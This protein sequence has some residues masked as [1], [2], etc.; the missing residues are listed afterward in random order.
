MQIEHLQVQRLN[1]QQLQGIA[2]LQMSTPEL[3]NYLQEV[4]QENPVIELYED[5][6]EESRY[7]QE[8]SLQHIEWLEN[9]D[10]QNRYYQSITNDESDPLLQISSPGGLE[11]TLANFVSHQ[12]HQ[13]PL[14][15]DLIQ[16]VQYLANCLDADGYLRVPLDALANSLSV[17]KT[18]ILQGVEILQSLEPAGIGAVNL[19]QC[20]ELQLRRSHEN[21]PALEIVQKYLD[22]LSKHHYR[23]IAA[24]LG[25]SVDTV[26]QARNLIQTL[27]PRPCSLFQKIEQV[28]YILPD[29][30]VDE[31]DGKLTVSLRPHQRSPFLISNYY[32]NILIQSNEKEVRDYLSQK[33]RQAENILWALS[34]REHTMLR[35]AQAIVRRQKDF[36]L[37]GPQKL[38]PL[39]ITDIAEELDLHDSTVSRAI[40]EKFL[41]CNKGIFP[42][43]YFFSHTAAVQ[44]SSNEQLSATAAKELLKRLISTEDKHH[45]LSDQK[46]CAFMASQGCPLSRRTVTKYRKILNIPNASLRKEI[47]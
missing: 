32:R 18:Q 39:R 46:L 5:I 23:L 4:A 24:K 35:C 45:P 26:Y 27:E 20:L 34:Q 42:L 29:I 22:E 43:H 21:G 33:T 25:V 47:H 8:D 2:I 28:H 30:F 41:Q 38:I 13:M 15:K 16:I 31:T 19:S 40:R 36:F 37:F 9:N 12:L 11:Y 7:F 3:Q 6:E 44:T 1:Q 10:Y 14:P 17:S